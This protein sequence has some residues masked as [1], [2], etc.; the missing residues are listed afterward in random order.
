[1]FY[2]EW[3]QKSASLP[4]LL[5]YWVCTASVVV[6]LHLF[7]LLHCGFSGCLNLQAACIAV[8]PPRFKDGDGNGV[9]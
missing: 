5:L 1:M 4:T 2:S 6:A 9:R 7:A 8:L 3:T